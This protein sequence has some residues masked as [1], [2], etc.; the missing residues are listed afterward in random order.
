MQESYAEAG[1][2]AGRHD[3]GQV[4]LS[5]IH[6]A[7][8]L[9]WEAV[10]ILNLSSGQFPNERALES[11]QGLEEE[12]RL[13]YVAVTRAKKQLYLTY[14]LMSGFSA[15][16]GGPSMFLEEINKDLFDEHTMAS[17]I[18]GTVSSVFSD[19]SDPVDDIQYVPED[20]PFVSRNPKRTFLKSIDEL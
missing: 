13:L 3:D 17:G 6:Q 2:R 14:P 15:V 11:D 1:T 4:V 5:T 18:F 9:E 10:F 16:L 20:E 12:R 19:P 7:K 8:G